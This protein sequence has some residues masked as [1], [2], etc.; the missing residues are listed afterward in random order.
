MPSITFAF[1]DLCSLVGKKLN[2][3]ELVRLL[4]YAKAELDSKFGAEITVKYNDTNQPYLWCVE[5]LAR[6][7]KGVI[8]KQKGLAKITVKK[9]SV[10][11]VVDKRVRKIRPCIAGFIAKGVKLDDYLLKQLV[12]M[13][14]KLSSNFGR[15]REKISI[16]TYPLKHLEFP[17]YYK[18]AEP[19]ESFTP[20]SFHHS[21][22]LRDVLDKHEKGKEFGH[23]LK[24]ESAYPVLVDAKKDILSLIPIINSEQTGRL[25]TGDDSFFFEVTGTDERSVNLVANSA[26]FACAERGFEIQA[27]TVEYPERKVVTP[28]L[29]PITMKFKEEEVEKLLGIKL[30]SGQLKSLLEGMRHGYS[31]GVVTV[32]SYRH[33]VMHPVDIVED[34]AIMYGYDNFEASPLTSYTVGSAKP[35]QRLIDTFRE[36]WVGAGYQEVLSPV[37]TNKE[38]LY[39]KMHVPDKGTIELENFVSMTYSCVRSWI[40]PVTLEILSKNK[41]VEYPQKIFEQ[42]VVTIRSGEPLDEEHIAGV[43]A[44]SLATFT[45][46]KQV[47]E[48]VLRSVGAVPEFDEFE[49]GCFIPGRAAS[50]SINGTQI[51]FVG[52][53]HPQVLDEFGLTTPVVGVELNLSRLH[54]LLKK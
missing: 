45:E 2:E 23:L 5:G 28:T 48:S 4:D 43:S 38:L 46:G 53:I 52:E 22:S 12:Q 6:L 39:G 54:E 34:V 20:L 29:A 21:V 27:V 14:E 8:G 44:H 25:V 31:N 15:K 13:Q 17:V 30:K 42:G 26:A 7:L 33:D 37:L 50:V 19:S 1:D 11:I 16:G 51:G 9:P 18:L 24:K 47:V 35:M 36:L 40:L 41:H 49:L 32:P 3:A 10:K